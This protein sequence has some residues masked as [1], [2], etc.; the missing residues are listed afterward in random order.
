MD[1]TGTTGISHPVGTG[2]IAENDSIA[3]PPATFRRGSGAGPTKAGLTA[4]LGAQCCVPAH[5][6]RG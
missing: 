3:M 5:L 2:A 4:D 1:I 6:D